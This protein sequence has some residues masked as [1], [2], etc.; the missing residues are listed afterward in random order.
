MELEIPSSEKPVATLSVSTGESVHTHSLLDNRI[1][2][3]FF[4]S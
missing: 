3:D 4:I 1:R 2:P